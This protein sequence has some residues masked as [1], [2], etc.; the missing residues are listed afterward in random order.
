MGFLIPKISFYIPNILTS[1]GNVL[2]TPGYF[3]NLDLY[4]YKIFGTSCSSRQNGSR[5]TWSANQT[6]VFHLSF[7]QPHRFVFAWNLQLDFNL[8]YYSES[9]Y[10]SLILFI[11]LPSL[12]WSLGS[13]FFSDLR[14][15][16]H[17]TSTCCWRRRNPAW[18]DGGN[19]SRLWHSYQRHG[20]LQF[21]LTEIWFSEGSGFY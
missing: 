1:P 10:S 12:C 17:R 19:L 11:F 4:S 2:P 20:W 16:F 9:E 18:Q 15:F 21:S 6:S 7:K 5:D 8:I 13:V 14:V 3:V